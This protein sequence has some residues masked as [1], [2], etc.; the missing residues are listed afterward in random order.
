M[1]PRTQAALMGWRRAIACGAAPVHVHL[2]ACARVSAP[3]ACLSE[4]R[5]N[6]DYEQKRRQ[7]SGPT[8]QVCKSKGLPL[9]EGKAAS[10]TAAT[11]TNQKKEKEGGG[12]G[13]G[14]GKG[15]KKKKGRK[16]TRLTLLGR[17]LVWV[18]ACKG[19]AFLFGFC[20]L[21]LFC[22]LLL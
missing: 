18:A 17:S 22:V 3:S 14:K 13:K 11:D 16:T 1:D 21:L 2:F 10:R 6:Q 5:F 19:S 12:N 7:P 9:H 20:W 15:E 8:E 4:V